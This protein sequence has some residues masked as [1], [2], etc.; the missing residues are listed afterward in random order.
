MNTAQKQRIDAITDAILK[1]VGVAAKLTKKTEDNSS[2][3]GQ[4]MKVTAAEKKA[5]SQKGVV[6]SYFQ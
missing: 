5:E 3:G 1:R 4:K 2:A 6:D